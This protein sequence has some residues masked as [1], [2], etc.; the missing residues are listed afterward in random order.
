[1]EHDYLRSLV[2]RVEDVAR[3]KKLWSAGD[4]IIVAVSGGPDSVALLHV[5]HEI[6]SRRTPLKLVCAHVHHGFR[7]ESDDEA[8][9]VQNL[10]ESLG[11]PVE[12]A[13]I[14]VPA[15]MEQ[16][17][18]GLQEAA[19]D[20][21]YEFLFETAAKYGAKSI[22]LAHHADDQAETVLMRLLRGTGPSGLAGMKIKRT[23]KNVKLI[24]PLL[25][26]NKTDLLDLCDQS[27]YSYAVD[28]SNLTT[29]YRR[30][31]VR[32]EVLPFLER[33]NGQISS[34]LNQLAEVIGEEDDFM[35]LA[36]ENAYRSYVRE[37]DGRLAFDAP[38][39]LG[40]H[41]ALQRRLIKLILNYLSADQENSDFVKI[42]TV[43]QG[44]LQDRRTNW[45]LD[46]GGGLTC[47]REYGEVS[48]MPKPL[49]RQGNYIYQLKSPDGPDLALPEIGK[50]LRLE[51]MNK[52]EM[53]D[54]IN[55]SSGE[56]SFDADQLVFPLTVRCRQPGDKMKI[57]GLNGS[58]KVKD[59]LIDEK[60]PPSVRS[61]I[62]IVCDGS[63]S[64]VWIPGVRR[65]VH[66]AVGRHTS[67]I[68]RMEL[69]DAEKV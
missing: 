35:D 52:E 40:L 58:K 38:S 57:M 22:A 53:R 18:K 33:Y 14:D 55:M 68:L 2:E 56:A 1:M 67:C 31:A 59:I 12:T 60:V 30:N 13:Y 61:M 45:R 44:V 23:Q 36:A 8:I 5:L 64:I 10:A 29:K 54:S 41:V 49:E 32:L 20:K 25:R 27:G 66:A 43:R 51:R 47:I 4:V 42:E 15:Y 19:R 21:R 63:G 16:S 46:L 65:S 28:C 26:I 48:F 6:S 11:I 69:V 9:M 50:I 39:F 62:P 24:R 34:S 7:Q 17:G 37:I 3:E